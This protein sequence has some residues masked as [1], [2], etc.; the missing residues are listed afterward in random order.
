MKK[1]IF[2]TVISLA[3]VIVL[4]GCNYA[5]QPSRAPAINTA[6]TANLNQPVFTPPQIKEVPPSIMAQVQIQNFAFNPAT[7]TIP[8]GASVVWTN[9][10]SAPHAIA[11]TGFNSPTLNNGQTFSN[12]F[13][14]AGT[15]DYHCSIHPSM[16]GQIIVTQ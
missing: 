3:V 10:D 12:T 15:F 13:Y 16:T 14:Q 7:L 1:Y 9:N 8:I 4:G 2:L 11:G 5:A 6:P